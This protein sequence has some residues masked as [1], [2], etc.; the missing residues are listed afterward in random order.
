MQPH[1][2]V[3]ALSCSCS[4]FVILAHMHGWLDRMEIVWLLVT[5]LIVCIVTT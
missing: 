5:K 2:R 3:R 1:L 4:V